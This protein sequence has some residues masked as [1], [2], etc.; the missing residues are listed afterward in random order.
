MV[1]GFA[2]SRFLKASSSS[3]YE[4]RWESSD[5]LP[6]RRED[7][8]PPAPLGTAAPA[9]RGDVTPGNLGGGPPDR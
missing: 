8:R 4:A 6:A 2:A 1:L 9:P 3:R 5:R 7:V